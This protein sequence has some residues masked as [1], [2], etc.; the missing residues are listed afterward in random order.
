V[1]VISVAF[2]VSRLAGVAVP[3]TR[4]RMM[5]CVVVPAGASKKRAITGPVMLEPSGFRATCVVIV[6]MPVPGAMSACQPLATIT[7]PL[8]RKSAK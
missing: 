6:S 7:W 8:A 2:V 1:C 3:V 5:G 4:P